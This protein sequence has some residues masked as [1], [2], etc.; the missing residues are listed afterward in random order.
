MQASDADAAGQAT[1]DP[2]AYV[3][4]RLDA[5]VAE[6]ADFCRLPSWGVRPAGMQATA[7]WLARK[8]VALGFATDVIEREDSFPLIW[9][10]RP[11]AS[12]R[13][14]LCFDHYEIADHATG[15]P[16]PALLD[17]LQPE[18][19]DGRLYCR[20]VADDKGTLLARVH[21]VEAVL[22]TSGQLPCE[23]VFMLEGK[24]QVS[25]PALPPYVERLVRPLQP[26]LVLWE[27][28]PKDERERPTMSLGAKGFMYVE[29][30][31]P[32][33]AVQLPS[34][35]NI[36]PNPAWD[37]TWAL[38]SLKDRAERVLVD[39]FYDDVRPLSVEDQG[40]LDELDT[41]DLAR[42]LAQSE[43]DGFL[44]G[45]RGR[46]VVERLYGQP[47]VTICALDSGD[48]GPEVRVAIPRRARAK[49]EFRLVA[50]Q[51]PFDILAKI[52]AHLERIGMAHL[53]VNVMGHSTPYATP[54]GDPCVQAVQRAARRVY[55]QSMIAKPNS[56][57]M[58]QKY[59]FRPAP[60]AGIGVEYW[61]SHAEQADEHIRVQDYR[62]GV[63][64]IIATFQELAAL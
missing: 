34:R 59:L 6:L 58:S 8:L 18:L 62:E 28:G 40:L 19:R 22:A 15:A 27:T 36:F 63:K 25:D 51:E 10:R 37:L 35:L 30:V 44:L 43:L 33:S 31:V 4:G 13:I 7:A 46:Q 11:G 9:A 48:A 17:G 57:G 12:Q 21:A 38:A 54:L 29:L 41:P 53:Q 3:D 56:T 5:F 60:T 24:R 23:V 26:D 52:R 16:P 45:E 55:G 32:G 49:V 14:A 61:G 2:F 39:G 1:T 20:G 64:Q 47:S 50:D 42:M